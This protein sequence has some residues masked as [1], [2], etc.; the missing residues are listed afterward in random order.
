VNYAKLAEALARGELP[1]GAELIKRNP[2]RCVVRCGDAVLKVFLRGPRRAQREARVLAEALR[3]GIPVPEPLAAGPGWVA[4]RYLQGRDAERVDL[5]AILPVVTNMHAQGMLHGDL[6][7]GNIWITDGAPVL[8]DVQRARFL[9]VVPGLLRRRELGYL[10]FSLGEPLPAAL[11]SVRFWRDRRAQVHWRSRT[12]RCVLE[13]LEFTA[14]EGGFRRRSADPDALR[15]VLEHPERA[16]PLKE[17][18]RARIFRSG[19]WILKEH[20]SVRTARA[21]WIGARGL[22]A[23][24][25]P[26]ASALAWRG[27]WLVMEDAGP[28]LSDWIESSYAAAAAGETDT[29]ADALGELL[30]A[31]HRRGIY[32][33]DLKANNV[34]WSPGAPP[35][36]LDYGR[37]RFGRSVSRRRRVK[38]LAQLNAALPDIVP[39]AFRTRAFTRYLDSA[40]FPGDPTTLRS[41]VITESLRRQH[42]WTGC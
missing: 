27:R 5:A 9:P 42:N 24:R 36:L 1:E 7:R 3:R 30:A 40:E 33:A 13:S 39:A 14:F 22:D 34:A 18:P 2:V 23:R 20:R 37:V 25:I 35:R 41:D 4:T 10:A 21:A 32:H 28:T 15:R 16:Q 31:L 6:H 38:N 17:L 19:S 8:L 29:L 12:R 11:S 26:A